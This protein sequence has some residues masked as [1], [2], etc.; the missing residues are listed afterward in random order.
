MVAPVREAGWEFQSSAD[1]SLFGG[2]DDGLF[3]KRKDPL[4]IHSY[5]PRIKKKKKQKMV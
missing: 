2:F 1:L 3:K 4:H 5:T